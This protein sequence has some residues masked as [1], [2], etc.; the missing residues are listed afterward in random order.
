MLRSINPATGQLQYQ[1]DTLDDKQ[2]E[3]RIDAAQ[4]AFQDWVGAGFDGRGQVLRNM[5]ALMRDEVETLAAL[6]TDEMGKPAGEARGE[7]EKAAWCAEHYAQYAESYLRSEQIESDAGESYV[8]YLPLGVILGILPWN[9]PF[10][11]AL[12]FA[13][14]TLMAGNTCLMKH[15]PNVDRKS[16]R[17]NSSHVAISYAVFCLKKKNKL[18]Q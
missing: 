14:P 16:T 5:A 13:A 11:L 10:W 18:Y 1:V 17:L 2:L 7:V 8:Q 15:D 4:T 3:Q 9:A 6:M 12:R